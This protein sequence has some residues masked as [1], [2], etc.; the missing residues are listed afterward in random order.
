MS[1]RDLLRGLTSPAGSIDASGVLYANPALR[2]LIA[3]AAPG[4]ALD[5]WLDLVQELARAT[6][7]A[8]PAAFVEARRHALDQGQPDAFMLRQRGEL[9]LEF[10][11]SAP[12]TA[13]ACSPW[14]TGPRPSAAMPCTSAPR[15]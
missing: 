2:S 7:H 4:A 9:H 14:S 12:S 3:T 8:D 5:R 10:S 13:P 6:S 11:R 15:P 1:V